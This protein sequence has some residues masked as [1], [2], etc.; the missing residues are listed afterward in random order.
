MA[1]AMPDARF[2]LV[3]HCGHLAPLEQPVATTA[4]MRLWLTAF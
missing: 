2:A 1:A 3:E 4:L